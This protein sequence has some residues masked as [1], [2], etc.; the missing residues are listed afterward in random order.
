[1]NINKYPYTDFHELNLD[2]FLAQFKILTDAWD[3]QKVDYEQFKTDV[4]TEFNTL[5]GKFDTLED[6][7]NDLKS[8]IETY[9]DDLDLQE[10][11]NIK[12][13]QM[14][15]DGTLSALIQPLFD[16]YKEDIDEEIDNQNTRLSLL[17]TRMDDF[18]SLPAGSTAGN[19]ELLDTRI[20]YDGL[21]YNSAGNSVR[22]QINE[23]LEKILK[24]SIPYNEVGNSS[25][26]NHTGTA[27]NYY[28]MEVEIPPYSIVKVPINVYADCSYT[29]ILIGKDTKT[30]RYVSTEN[31]ITGENSIYL[32]NTSDEI[33]YL[34]VDASPD[35][36]F[37]GSSGTMH[38][39][40]FTSSSPSIGE[41]HDYIF[42]RYAGFRL[43][44]EIFPDIVG[45]INFLDNKLDDTEDIIDA[46][47][48]LLEPYSSMSF[49]DDPSA[50]VLGGCLLNQPFPFD[51][52]ITEIR[53]K[54]GTY[55]TTAQLRIYNWDGVTISQDAIT[56][57]YTENINI[58]NG[59]AS[60]NIPVRA[61][62]YLGFESNASSIILWDN[63]LIGPGFIYKPET[64]SISNHP[65]KY[66][67]LSYTMYSDNYIGNIIAGQLTDIRKIS[68]PLRDKIIFLAGDSRSSADYTFYKSTM[69]AKTN[70]RALNLGASGRNAAYNASDA[71]FAT[72]AANPHDFSIWLVGGNDSGIAGSIGTFSADSPL[73][74]LGESVVTE[75]DINVDY[76]GTTF[77]QA[78]DHIMRKY[79]SLYYDFKT[80]N[81]GHKPKM[82][83]CTDLP[84]KRVSA[85][86]DWSQPENWERKRLA[87]LECA[88][89]NNV[90]CLDL[91]ML[92]NFD[93]SYEPYW[94][95]PTDFVNDNGVYFMD[96][97]H[98]N[99]YGCD[100]MT[101][102]EIEEMKKYIMINPYPAT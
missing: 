100:I 6:A 28:V 16:E 77:I 33:C 47:K 90:A 85:A 81:N 15:S 95:S 88:E 83:F 49:E 93:M 17:E 11:V 7:F 58:V 19:A 24:Y 18:A 38:Y 14:A 82:I 57:A 48:Y 12:L 25:L 10:E 73:A 1:M 46:L 59:V 42:N 2:W 74:Q 3:A 23:I 96:G 84:Q 44:I 50:T 32:A 37:Y 67:T 4:T 60:V 27:N 61:G 51:G 64:S 94:T 99:R 65:N 20:A 97:L 56:I 62:Q 79:K 75:T 41:Y 43:G 53:C 36:T 63:N 54:S 40:I 76:N 72:V 92:C 34:A 102:L 29:V 91:Y 45:K 30:F 9:F 52:N 78:I 71:Y 39:A 89:K 80:L 68:E 8:Y 98:P 5:S 21:T 69:E 31:L 35:K 26:T 55:H 87:I 13:N 86:S 101:S 70:G 22:G 66:I